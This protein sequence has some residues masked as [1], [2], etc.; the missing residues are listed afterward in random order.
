MADLYVYGLVPTDA[1][2]V[3]TSP[4]GAATVNAD[5]TFVVVIPGAAGQPLQSITWQFL[6]R[7]GHLLAAGSGPNN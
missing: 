7:D 6:D 1:K 2:T 3:E 5:G 4:P